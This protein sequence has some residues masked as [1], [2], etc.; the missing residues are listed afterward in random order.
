MK[1]GIKPVDN[2]RNETRF[3]DTRF[4][5]MEQSIHHMNQKMDSSIQQMNHNLEQ[6]TQQINQTLQRFENRFD[7]IDNEIKGIKKDVGDVQKELKGEIRSNFLWTLGVIGAVLGVVAHGF[8][9]F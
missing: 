2:Y 6:F 4:A 7:K 5:L 3:N 8:H 9:W 1:T